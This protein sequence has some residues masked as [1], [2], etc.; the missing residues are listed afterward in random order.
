MQDPHTGALQ[1]SKVLAYLKKTR[2]TLVA[3]E[4]ANTDSALHQNGEVFGPGH[5]PAPGFILY[6][7]D[8]LHNRFRG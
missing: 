1:K 3:L 6:F 4:E 7:Q 2:S 8:N 5:A